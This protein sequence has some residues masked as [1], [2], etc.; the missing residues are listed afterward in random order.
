MVVMVK[1][2]GGSWNRTV[3]VTRLQYR[4]LSSRYFHMFQR[5]TVDAR[6]TTRRLDDCNE[7]QNIINMKYEL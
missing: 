3:T 1:R 7:N 4:T 6:A 5:T 2:E